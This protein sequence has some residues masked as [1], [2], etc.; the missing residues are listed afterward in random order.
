ML[1]NGKVDLMAKKSGGGFYRA[2]IVATGMRRVDGIVRSVSDAGVVID[3]RERGRRTQK[4]TL[5][6]MSSV[7]CHTGEGAGFV[8]HTG[9]YVLEPI[10]GEVVS[11]GADG[12]VLKDADGVEVHFPAG[13]VSAVTF[14][15]VDGEDRTVKKGNVETKVMRL[16]EREDGSGKKRKAKEKSAK[17]SV[18][19]RRKL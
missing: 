8:V 7:V 4:A 19:K 5:I 16:S 15:S 6:P 14:V 13:N 3:I 2:D 17:K 11:E 10:A 18:G 12:V 1:K 9:S